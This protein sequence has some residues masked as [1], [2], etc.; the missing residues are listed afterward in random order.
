MTAAG[1]KGRIAIKAAAAIIP[2]PDICPFRPRPPPPAT[3]HR[4]PRQ[5]H[6]LRRRPQ[7]HRSYQA[8]KGLIVLLVRRRSDS[9]RQHHP[10]PIPV[11]SQTFSSP[12]TSNPLEG[13]RSNYSATVIRRVARNFP[14]AT[15]GLDLAIASDLPQAA[16][17]SSSSAVVVAIFLALARANNLRPAPLRIP[18]PH[19][20]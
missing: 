13:H 2:N 9:P 1:A 17:L 12:P 8:E 3:L 16:G 7:S 14:G 20:K 19:P 18:I 15:I 5:T 4:V 6:R 11:K 10:A